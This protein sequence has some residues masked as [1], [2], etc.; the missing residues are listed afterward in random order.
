MINLVIAV[1]SAAAVTCLMWLVLGVHVAISAPFGL[2]VGVVTFIFLGRKVQTA[3]EGIMAQMQRDV[4]A[5]KLDR[6]IDTLKRGYAFKNRHIF[7]GAQL[8]SQIGMLYYIKKDHDAAMAHLQKGFAKHYVG[9][10]MMAAIHYKRKEYDAMKK[11]M[12]VAVSANKKESICY[13]LYAY[14]LSQ[15]KEKDQAIEILRKG[16][17]KLPDDERLT[18][19]L[20][21]L[22]NN[23]KMKMK[24]YG[25]IW[26]QFML[27]RAPRM[28]QEPPQHMR[29]RRRA[30]FR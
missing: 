9:Q 5:G 22:Q 27:E 4:Q 3:L 14:F 20:T 29:M 18:T 19:N 16:L 2:V 21:Q 1:L 24:V 13:A 11:A 12:D 17:K 30:M 10:C 25:D 28:M 26:T 6:A 23:K 8:N 7:V 15:I